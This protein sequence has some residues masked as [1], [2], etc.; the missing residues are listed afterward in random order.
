MNETTPVSD[1]SADNYSFLQDFIQSSSGIVLDE[2][3]RYLLEARLIPITREYRIP[4]LDNLCEALRRGGDAALSRDVVD[5]ITTN[6]TLFFRDIGLWDA[7]RTNLI[8]RLVELRSASRCIRIWSA[9]SSSGQEAYSLAITL[10]ELG[11]ADWRLEIFG[12]DICSR[13][14]ARARE[15]KFSSLEVNR[16]L[17]ARFLVKYFRQKGHL[18]EVAPELM[19]AVHFEQF[20][21][22]GSMSSLGYFDLILCRNVLIYFDIETKRKILAGIRFRLAADGC[23]ILGGSETT[24]NIDHTFR[25][26]YVGSVTVHTVG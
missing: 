13:M 20:D 1:I 3:K 6:E 11:L 21:L 16:G 25:Q 23:L 8:P 12:T 19:R 5:A 4:G 24:W 22:R 17:P 18:W 15:G 7:L 9:A 26:E 14:V 2:G 10:H